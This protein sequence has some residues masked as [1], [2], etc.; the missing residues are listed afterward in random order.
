MYKKLLKSQTRLK[1]LL[2]FQSLVK[3]LLKFEIFVQNTTK[4]WNF[5]KNTTK[6]WKFWA[7]TTKIWNF[8]TNTTKIWTYMFTDVERN[9]KQSR[10][11]L[12]HARMR[13]P[14]GM[15][16]IGFLQSK[17][18]VLDCRKLS[19]RTNPGCILG[20][21]AISMKFSTR[22]KKQI[23]HDIHTGIIYTFGWVTKFSFRISGDPDH[24]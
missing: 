20:L 8:R 9:W 7:N 10:E 23:F 2:R 12:C 6:I 13:W 5:S 19:Y 24:V 1:I 22:R 18:V 14:T 11:F 15:V 4:I 3:I 21:S 16:L 17:G